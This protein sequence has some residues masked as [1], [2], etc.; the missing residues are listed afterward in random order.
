MKEV[1]AGTHS[2]RCTV[3]LPNPQYDEF[4]QS[5]CH[6]LDK[7]L[8]GLESIINSPVR[9]GIKDKLSNTVKLKDANLS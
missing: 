6:K 5:S 3:F 8:R 2:A 4:G 9:N 1:L 7:D